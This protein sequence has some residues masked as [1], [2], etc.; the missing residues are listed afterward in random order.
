M[1]SNAALVKF[2]DRYEY[3]NID[4]VLKIAISNWLNHLVFT[5]R[6][7]SLE[8][9]I[10]QRY[11]KACDDDEMNKT[12]KTL[13]KLELYNKNRSGNIRYLEN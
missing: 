9:M 4:T 10:K 12:A 6:F 8:K 1:R 3:K 11:E 7:D 13:M 5:D 2:R